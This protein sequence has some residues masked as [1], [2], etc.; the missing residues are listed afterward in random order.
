MKK[1]QKEDDKEEKAILPS[2]CYEELYE[3]SR[4][5]KFTEARPKTN[6]FCQG[7]TYTY[8]KLPAFPKMKT[9]KPKTKRKTKKKK[10]RASTSDNASTISILPVSV[11]SNYILCNS[12]LNPLAS[13]FNFHLSN[14]SNC[15]ETLSSLRIS[16][17]GNIIIAHL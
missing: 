13:P 16:N 14:A 12:V 2:I 11:D 15:Y 17:T 4:W 5:D 8:E 10:V 7:R 9:S 3:F 6:V 1:S